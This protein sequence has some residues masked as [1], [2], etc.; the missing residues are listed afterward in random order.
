MPG[1]AQSV[2]TPT[3]VIASVETRPPVPRAEFD[4]WMGIAAARDGQTPGA[5][6]IPV[7]DHPEYAVC[8][9][10]VAKTKAGRSKTPAQ[11]RAQCRKT[12]EGLRDQVLGFLLAARWVQG[13]AAEQGISVTPQQVAKAFAQQKEQ[14]FPKDADYRKFLRESGSTEAD[15][16]FQLEIELLQQG[17]VAKVTKG[18]DRV[19][20]AEIEAYYRENREQF[21][22]PESRD[23]RVVLTKSRS[24]ALRA[25]AAVLAGRSWSSVAKRYSI[26][27][28]S[29]NR[30]GKL[31]GVTEGQQ[32]RALD[33]AVFKA[34]RGQIRGPVRTQFGYYVFKVIRITPPVQQTLKQATPTI[35]SL[36][37]SENQQRAL[38]AFVE[39]Y[40]AKWKA[41]T[42]CLTGYVVQ[43]CGAALPPQAPPA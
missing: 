9:A 37:A 42:G 40:R 4:R 17:L 30:D 36:V 41:R 16:R 38:D 1:V 20:R 11:R 10:R 26:D 21:A 6:P 32:E 2:G 33:R 19:T 3:D 39:S 35:K 12:W 34:R 18:S 29:K 15:I 8:A 5:A 13:E 23:L 27:E 28:A 22:T 25:R 24:R 14:A 31:V 7:P 43:D